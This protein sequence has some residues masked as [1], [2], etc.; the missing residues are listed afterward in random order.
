MRHGVFNGACQRNITSIKSDAVGSG[1]YA[2]V[3]KLKIRKATRLPR[4]AVKGRNAGRRW[5]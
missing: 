3:N 5:C 2:H 1:R 4:E